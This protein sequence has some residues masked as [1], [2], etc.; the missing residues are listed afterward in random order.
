MS[1]LKKILI[2]N[3][4]E[5]AIRVIRACKELG[6]KTVAIYSEIEK[7]AMHVLL[8]DESVCV[9][10]PKAADSYLNIPSILSAAE[11]TDSGAIHPGYGFLSE[12]P[13]F[14]EA[15]KKSRITFIGPTPENIRLGGNKSRAKQ[16][17]RKHG[18]PVIP[19]SD[20]NIIDKKSAMGIAKKI[21]YPV[22]IKASAGGGGRGMRIVREESMLEQAFSAAEAES[23]AAFGVGDLYIEKYITLIRHIEVQIAVGSD[24]TAI[25]L[26]ERDCSVQRR[27]QKLIEES[28]SPVI[29]ERLREKLGKYAIKAAEVLKYRN[30]GTVEFIVDR[31]DSIY[32]MEINTRVQVEHPVTEAVTGVDIIKEQIRLASGLPLSI[33]QKNIKIHG[34]AIECRVNAEDPYTFVPSPGKITFLYLPG[35]PGIRVDTYVYSGCTVLPYYD[36]LIAKVISHGTTR[37]EAVDKM[38]RALSE[39]KIEGIKT[40]IPFHKTVLTNPDFLSGEFD[41]GYLERL[42]GGHI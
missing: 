31:D 26:G 9:G 23:L 10:P 37:K 25:H 30:V 33:K 24:G 41:T 20:G 13:H 3:R 16:I 29:T 8:A 34:H 5:I 12:N 39:F 28:P 32:F 6:I 17:L 35:G 42:K 36:S 14:A 27:H 22:I 21:G 18:I 15:C 19:G 1:L 40:T 38:K 7:D 4:G 2:A 11:I